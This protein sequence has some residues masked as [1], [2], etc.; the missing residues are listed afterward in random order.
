M[1]LLSVNLKNL[2]ER[3][4]MTQKELAKYMNI[5]Q[6]SIA[7]YEKGDRQ[8]PIQLLLD[9]SDF[10]GVSIDELVGNSKKNKS[11]RL[12]L[13]KDQALKDLYNYLLNKNH[14]KFMDYI[15]RL[16]SVMDLKIVIED[17][18]KELLYTI[19]QE[20]E[21]G[22][23]TEADEHYASNIIRK[24][25]SSL[26]YYDTLRLRR[27][28]SIAITV[29]SEKH[30]LGMELVSDLLEKQGIET[31]YLGSDVPMKSLMILI[32]E[33]SPD[34]LFISITLREYINNLLILIEKLS[35]KHIDK[36]FIGGQAVNKLGNALEAYDNVIII[37][38]LDELLE[39]I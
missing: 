39:K 30:S 19:G 31:L 5:S 20:W 1:S 22:N 33:Y 13:D 6:T 28:K 32:D 37:Y 18:L 14:S 34:Y 15:E 26:T 29:A 9:F 23:I 21:K 36:I 3:K 8:P 7:H 38:T 27:K 11:K 10:F 12:H 2:R 17:Y 16:L 25:V 4:K 24:S 35:E